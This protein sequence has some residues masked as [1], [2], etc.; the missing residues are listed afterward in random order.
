[1]LYTWKPMAA[2][3]LHVC[4]IWARIAAISIFV[5]PRASFGIEAATSFIILKRSPVS[6]GRFYA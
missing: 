6:T 5:W 4:G 3:S 2:V 1:M